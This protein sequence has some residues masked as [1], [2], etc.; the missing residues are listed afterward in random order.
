MRPV[1]LAV[2]VESIYRP[3]AVLHVGLFFGHS[4]SV[5][6]HEFV[7]ASDL[8]VSLEFPV[9]LAT[10]GFIDA[11]LADRL[12]IQICLLLKAGYEICDG[13]VSRNQD[14]HQLLNTGQLQD[15]LQQT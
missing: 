15:P 5:E 8:R 4:F 2:E 6:R 14:L 10:M 11:C 13:T 7:N 1:D 12:V 3:F 9:D